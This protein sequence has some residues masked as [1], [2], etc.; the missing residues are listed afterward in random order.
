M[1]IHNP[2]LRSTIILLQ[3]TLSLLA[4]VGAFYAYSSV[5][6]HEPGPRNDSSKGKIHQLDSMVVESLRASTFYQLHMQDLK[7]SGRLRVEDANGLEWPIS[8]LIG[9]GPKIILR[10][11]NLNCQV[12]V[13]DEIGRLRQVASKIGAEKI[14]ILSSY[15]NARSLQAFKR[16]NQLNSEVY[17]LGDTRLGLP[18]EAAN[19]PCVFVTDPSLR[20][21][22]TH[23]PTKEIPELSNVFYKVALKRYF[24]VSND[25]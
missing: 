14:L 8:R 25:M 23:V 18:S 16:A 5:R 24:G 11:S 13:D 4:I 19:V 1:R 10:Y 15:S 12:C 22:L 21:M 2:D 6:N 7:L 17:N 20:I 9:S 3:V